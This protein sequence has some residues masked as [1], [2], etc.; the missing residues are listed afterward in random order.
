MVQA[1]ISELSRARDLFRA[2]LSRR[3]TESDWQRFF[4]EHPYVLSLSLPVRLEPHEIT[5]LARPGTTEPDFV[6]YPRRQRPLPF[7]GAIELKRPD[8][9]IVTLTRANVALLTRDAQTAVEQAVA[10]ARRPHSHI[11]IEHPDEL[12]FLGNRAYLFV[13]MGMS[14]ELATKLGN[15]LYREAVDRHLPENLQLIPYD[16]LLRTFEGQLPSRIY[17]LR[18]GRDEEVLHLRSSA[19][20]PFSYEAATEMIRRYDFYDAERNPRGRS[21]PHRYELRTVHSEA[22]VVD[23]LTGLMWQQAGIPGWLTPTDA[24]RR[25]ESVFAG[26][27]GWRLPTLEEALSLLE[28]TR[29]SNGLHV[30]GRFSPEPSQIVTC[31]YLDVEVIPRGGNPGWWVVRLDAGTA[32]TGYPDYDGPSGYTGGLKAVRSMREG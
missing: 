24:F 25:L 13:I 8:S 30:D 14:A 3:T 22:V 15:E 12:L 1:G 7:F 28:P 27:R 11:P 9:R 16:T 17:F 6:F 26:Y 23:E 2:L 21:I 18:V 19:L 10:F 5:P 20:Y 29:A 31:D 32:D 4:S